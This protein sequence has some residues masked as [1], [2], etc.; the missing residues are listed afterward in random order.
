MLKIYEEEPGRI[1]FLSPQPTIESPPPTIESPP[2]ITESPQPITESPQPIIPQEIVLFQPRLQHNAPASQIPISPISQQIIPFQP[3]FLDS[4]SQIP[5]TSTV[6]NFCSF[7]NFYI[8]PESVKS[9]LM[10]LIPSNTAQSEFVQAEE[11]EEDRPLQ[12][13]QDV[14]PEQPKKIQYYPKEDKIVE[15][16]RDGK[17]I[18][19][20]KGPKNQA[21]IVLAEKLGEFLNE[22]EIKDIK[23]EL[24]NIH[25]RGVGDVLIPKHPH[26]FDQNDI[27]EQR[28]PRHVPDD[29]ML[30]HS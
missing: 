5:S 3:R 18:K 14:S 27:E 22:H 1:T 21:D 10:A 29:I 7:N 23:D 4:A 19:V 9:E 2:P 30:P 8:S 25:R 15:Q 20:W 16:I 24:S 17:K 11:Q 6:Y 12:I 26:R 28:Q 13:I